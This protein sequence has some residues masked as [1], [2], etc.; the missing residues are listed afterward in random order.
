MSILGPLVDVVH[1]VGSKLS[2][3]HFLPARGQTLSL[4]GVGPVGGVGVVV[5]VVLPASDGP[6]YRPT[7][8]QGEVLAARTGQVPQRLSLH[9]TDTC[10]RSVGGR[11]GVLLWW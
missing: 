11:G 7:T 6:V 5:D 8:G 4:Q 1:V 2:R 3:L 9:P 10:W